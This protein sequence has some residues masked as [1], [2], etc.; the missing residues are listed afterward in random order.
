MPTTWSSTEA[1]PRRLLSIGLVLKTYCFL[2]RSMVLSVLMSLMSL[3]F[4]VDSTLSFRAQVDR[5]VGQS[6]QTLYALRI[7]KHHGLWWASA[8]ECRNCYVVI[9]PLVCISC[10]VGYG[11]C[12]WKHRLQ[13][14]LNKAVKQGFLPKDQASLELL[15]DSAD[16]KLFA[17]ILRNPQHVLHQFLPPVKYTTHN[18]RSRAHKS[19]VT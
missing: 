18:L 17:S 14:V 6:A 5:L 16:M 8:L 12:W 11:G 19:S 15:C 4:L 2:P 9:P 13:S 7:L 10:V 1:R 3:V